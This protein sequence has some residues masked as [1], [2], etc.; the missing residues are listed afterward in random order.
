MRAIINREISSFFCSP[1]GYLV[2]GLFLCLNGLFL[3]LFKGNFN[4]LESGFADLYPF[5]QLAPWV[6]LLLIPAVTMSTIAQEKK[7][8][9]LELLL[10]HPIT[11]KHL[12]L[13]KFFGSF[14]L[15]ILALIPTLLYVYAIW[16]LA[17]PQG[18]IDLGSISGSYF[19]LCFLIG[20]YT[21]IGI[22]T[23]SCTENQITAFISAMLICFVCYY[24]LAEFSA[25]NGLNFLES[26]SLKYHY[27]SIS[28]GVLDLRDLIYFSSIICF[29]LFLTTLKLSHKQ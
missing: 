25:L 10:S 18:A 28:R 16:T 2:I 3:W 21:A 12:I 15:I 26:W 8:G 17:S 19:G 9:T 1:I 14:I 6:L 27:E 5:F 4:I 7:S 22:F 11:K 23:S 13:G 29:F 20:S 24:G